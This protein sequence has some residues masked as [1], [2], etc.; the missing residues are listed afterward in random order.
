M[1]Q[2][3]LLFALVAGSAGEHRKSPGKTPTQENLGQDLVANAKA[4]QQKVGRCE[5]L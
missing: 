1:Q 2:P 3:S 4:S 5:M